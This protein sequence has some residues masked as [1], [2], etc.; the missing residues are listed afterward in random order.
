MP[1]PQQ[2]S[3]FY[4]DAAI[5][6]PELKKLGEW[7]AARSEKPEL[8]AATTLSILRDKV[9]AIAT[10][11]VTV[12]ERV[13]IPDAAYEY[14]SKPEFATDAHLAEFARSVLRYTFN[15]HSFMDDQDLRQDLKLR[16]ER[17]Q[18]Y[19][20]SR[21]AGCKFHHEFA[22]DVIELKDC[23]L[24]QMRTMSRSPI[25]ERGKVARELDVNYLSMLKTKYVL[26][27]VTFSLVSY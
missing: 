20:E 18:K 26:G 2:N 1:K 5:L 12:S 10:K 25:A 27:E 11:S 15:G 17:A 24:F 16:K 23:H 22:K 8:N 21:F 13:P 9:K 4:T 3:V 7:C 6:L 19:V 14:V